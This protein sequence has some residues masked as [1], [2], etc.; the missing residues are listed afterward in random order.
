MQ[1]AEQTA[2][3]VQAL[4]RRFTYYAMPMAVAKKELVNLPIFGRACKCVQVY[5]PPLAHLPSFAQRVV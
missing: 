3:H 5:P 2:R 1:R 4:L